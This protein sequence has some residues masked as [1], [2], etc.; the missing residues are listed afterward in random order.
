MALR[1]LSE[2]TDIGIDVVAP[3]LGILN[4]KHI[5]WSWNVSGPLSTLSHN[6]LNGVTKLLHI[7]PGQN[8]EEDTPDLVLYYTSKQH[9]ESP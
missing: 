2:N 6:L 5:S 7:D 4:E 9:L 3:E 1:T 8:P